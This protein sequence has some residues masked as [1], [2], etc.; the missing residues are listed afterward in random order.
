MRVGL[1]DVD[2]FTFPRMTFPNLALMKISAYHKRQGDVVKFCD[3]PMERFDVVYQTKVFTEEYS[4]DIDW[5]PNAQKVIKGG[6]GYNIEG[7]LPY[8]IEHIY[9]DYHLYDGTTAECNDTAFGFLSRGCP[10]HC[11]FCIVGDKEGLRSH[12]VADLNEFWRGQKKIM[13]MDPNLTACLERMDLFRQ[14]ANSG[15]WVDFVQGL[16]ARLCDAKIL[17]AI[18]AVKTKIVHFSWDNPKDDLAG[19]FEFLGKNLR[20]QD[21]RRRIVYV[22]TN[23]GSTMD[24]NLYRIYTLESFGFNA[25]VRIFD[26]PNAPKE[27]KRLQRWCNNRIIHAKCPRFEDY[28]G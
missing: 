13:L 24:E 8:E 20:I 23:H 1:I 27:I 25:D 3:N 16:D 2:R 7:T 11:D 4:K 26:K 9:P 14:L 5:Y 6:T 18:N 22:L 28:K 19:R 21:H 10:R 17:P 15:A 12:K